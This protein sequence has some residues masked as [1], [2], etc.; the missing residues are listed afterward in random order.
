MDLATGKALM[1]QGASA[2]PY[3]LDNAAMGYS[4]SMRPTM[5]SYAG[6]P[7]H[8]LRATLELLATTS[9]T[10]STDFAED[11]DGWIGADFYR[12]HNLEGLL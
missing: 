6:L 3:G 4:H 1:A 5:S 11:S 12:L 8:H 9:V 7:E 2:F 10:S